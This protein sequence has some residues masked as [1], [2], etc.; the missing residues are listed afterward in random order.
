MFIYFGA[1]ASN[2]IEHVSEMIVPAT[3]AIERQLSDL[4]GYATILSKANDMFM[5]LPNAIVAL[6]ED[7][8][9]SK[10]D[11]ANI[12]Y[13]HCLIHNSFQ[14]VTLKVRRHRGI[15]CLIFVYVPVGWLVFKAL[16][17]VPSSPQSP[18]TD[19]QSVAEESIAV[20]GAGPGHCKYR[21]DGLS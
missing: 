9:P 5:S 13:L 2:S 10:Q 7:S 20:T 14:R 17:C 19:A 21:N 4:L 6:V 1:R 12:K 8:T 16:K 15:R 3:K 11:C 18:G